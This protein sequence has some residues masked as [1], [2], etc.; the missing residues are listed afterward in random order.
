MKDAMNDEAI[1]NQGRQRPAGPW[2]LGVLAALTGI[3]LLAA[4]CG[5]GSAATAGSTTP[6]TPYQKSLAYAE[7]M[8][9]HGEPSWPDPQSDGSFNVNIDLGSP[10]YQSANEACAHLEGGGQ[11]GGPQQHQQTFVNEALRYVACMRSH[12]IT[13]YPDPS[14]KGD[15]VTWGF[16]PASGIS[17]SSP[18]FQ[19]A[20]LT[21]RQLA[22]NGGSS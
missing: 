22:P 2:P 15:T 11:A 17:T 21:C 12:G 5:G 16:S 18:Q 6:Q 10:Q 20:S 9:S 4:A 1:S 8:R 7:C 19:S 13:N 3:C 14:V